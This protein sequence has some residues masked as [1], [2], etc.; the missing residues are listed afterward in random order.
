M[1][2]HVTKSGQ[3][4]VG[5]SDIWL[6]WA[7]ALKTCCKTGLLPC[8]VVQIRVASWKTAALET[9]WL[10]SWTLCEWEVNPCC[11]E[12]LRFRGSLLDLANTKGQLHLFL[13]QHESGTLLSTLCMSPH[14][15]FETI[16]WEKYYFL[17]VLYGEAEAQSSKAYLLRVIELQRC[18]PGP[19]SGSVWL[20]SL[21]KLWGFAET[22]GYCVSTPCR[23]K[24]FFWRWKTVQIAFSFRFYAWVKSLCYDLL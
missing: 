4:A 6:L 22:D 20:E 9:T 12:L 11:M 5:G 13:C 14:S 16:L 1:G 15:I 19:E 18:G 2:D 3:W 23:A 17:F 7:E 10:H 8:V 21:D 24:R